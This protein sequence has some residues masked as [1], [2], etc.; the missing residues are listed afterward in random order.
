MFADHSMVVLLLQMLFV[1]YAWVDP[2]AD[3]GSGPPPPPPPPQENYVKW[4]SIGN[5]QLVLSL[6]NAGPHSP[7][8]LENY[9]VPLK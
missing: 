4:V 8:T 6:K 7:G 3:R 9:S 5:K 1:I 2:E